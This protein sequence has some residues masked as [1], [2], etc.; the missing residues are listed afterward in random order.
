MELNLLFAIAAPIAMIVGINWFLQQGGYRRGPF[1]MP[2]DSAR[3]WAAVEK[4]N[5]R[6]E[7]ANDAED[8]LAA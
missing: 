5:L 8:R 2:S 7:A 1:V 4:R 6:L 3:A